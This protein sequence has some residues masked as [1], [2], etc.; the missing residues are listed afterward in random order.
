MACFCSPYSRLL[1]VSWLIVTL[2]EIFIFQLWNRLYDRRMHLVKR[3]A[4]VT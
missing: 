3:A 4:E 2:K 1:A